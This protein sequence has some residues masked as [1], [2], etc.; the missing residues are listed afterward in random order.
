MEIDVIG[1]SLYDSNKVI[2]YSTH[3]KLN[4]NDEIVVNTPC[5]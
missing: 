2:T 5:G 4:V 3:L 1:E